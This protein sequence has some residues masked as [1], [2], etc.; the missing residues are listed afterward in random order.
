M[1]ETGDEISLR[2]LYLTLG[3]GFPL[4]IGLSSLAAVVAFGVASVRPERFQ[5]QATG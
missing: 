2:S 1:P 5:A 4:I 3:R